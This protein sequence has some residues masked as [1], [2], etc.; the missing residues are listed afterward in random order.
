M[1]YNMD[2]RPCALPHPPCVVWNQEKIVAVKVD[3]LLHEI[4]GD[5]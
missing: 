5:P 3:V 4:V 2:E 1:M